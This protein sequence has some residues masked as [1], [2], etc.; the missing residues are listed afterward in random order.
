MSF[1]N[2]SVDGTTFTDANLTRVTSGG[3][4]GTPAAQP[5]SWRLRNGYFVG[6]TSNL[7]GANLA[8]EALNGFNLTGATLTGANLTNTILNGAN[9]TGANLTSAVLTG[10]NLTNATLVNATWTHAICPDGTNA[11]GDGGT[12][13]NNLS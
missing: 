7:N 13:A 2:A 12:C 5:T 4:S 6:P 3:V 9:L 8:G 11:D 1:T 10:A